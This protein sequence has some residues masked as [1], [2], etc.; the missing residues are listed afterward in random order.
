MDFWQKPGR[1]II[2]NL[3]GN[4]E[5]CAGM[6]HGR[7]LWSMIAGSNDREGMKYAKTL[8]LHRRLRQLKTKLMMIKRVKRYWLL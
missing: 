4:P 7:V 6:S 5:R 3:E 8:I 1:Q 2:R